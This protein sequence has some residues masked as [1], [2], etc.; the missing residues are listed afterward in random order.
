MLCGSDAF[1]SEQSEGRFLFLVSY[2]RVGT[3]SCDEQCDGVTSSFGR[4][5]RRCTPYQVC[6]SSSTVADLP[7]DDPRFNGKLKSAQETA[8]HVGGAAEGAFETV[9]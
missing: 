2:F 9:A 6:F 5:S 3:A 8:A 4:P 7:A 1:I